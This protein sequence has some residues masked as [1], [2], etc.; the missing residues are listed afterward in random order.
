MLFIIYYKRTTIIHSPKLRSNDFNFVVGNLYLS[1]NMVFEVGVRD[2]AKKER[3]RKKEGA[4][5]E[6]E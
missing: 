2:R 1:F 5:E 3:R 6:R 4:G